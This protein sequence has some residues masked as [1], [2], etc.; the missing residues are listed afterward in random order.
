ME[1]IRY[2]KVKTKGGGEKAKSEQTYLDKVKTYVPELVVTLWLAAGP[3]ISS[4]FPKEED[5]LGKSIAL[6]IFFTLGIIA[7]GILTYRGI[8][9][10]KTKLNN[11]KL[12]L[13]PQTVATM[14]SFVMWVLGTG[15]GPFALFPWFSDGIG[16][17]AVLGWTLG[18]APL[19]RVNV[20]DS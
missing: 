10:E 15:G 16:K 5:I 6:W 2:K 19:L 14:V 4:T 11:P 7:S 9:A 8:K 13:A 3:L 1:L 18:I 20:Q 17:L 12:K